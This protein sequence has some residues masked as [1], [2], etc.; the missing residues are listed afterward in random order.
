M[1]SCGQPSGSKQ[2]DN[3]QQETT[4]NFNDFAELVQQIFLDLPENFLPEFAYEKPEIRHQTGNHK[5]DFNCRKLAD[6][7]DS[8]DFYAQWSWEMA[9]YMKDD[10][11][12]VAV[13]VEYEDCTSGAPC[14]K[15]AYDLNYNI[16]TGKFTEI[17]IENPFYL[18]DAFDQKHPQIETIKEIV[19]LLFYYPDYN[20]YVSTTYH[21]D[22]YSTFVNF[23]E[24]WDDVQHVYDND[25][26]LAKCMKPV[27]FNFKWNGNGF[28]QVNID[29]L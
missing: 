9:A 29:F 24:F 13:I 21:K 16:Q 4:T 6:E 2:K 11:Q 7:W 25:A 22:G 28:E 14:G 5:D 20:L 18:I 26:E 19:Q 10:N 3:A 23:K 27:T 12:N 15:L 17:E 1:A 8:G